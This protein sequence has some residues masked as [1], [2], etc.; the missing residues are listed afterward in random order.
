MGILLADGFDYKARKPLDARILYD[1][2][3]D[4]AGMTDAVMYEGAIA[5]N[6]EDNKFYVF[7]SANTVDPTTGKWRELNTGGN[8]FEY[9]VYDE[10]TTY[11]KGDWVKLYDNSAKIARVVQTHTVPTTSTI[12]DE[13]YEAIN[14]GKI[15]LVNDNTLRSYLRGGNYQKHEIIIDHND[16]LY[17]TTKAFEAADVEVPDGGSGYKIDYCLAEDLRLGNMIPLDKP[18]ISTEYVIGDS[19]K[20]GQTIV[21]DEKIYLVL[22]DFTATDFNTDLANFNLSKV[23][24]NR[25]ESYIM[26]APYKEGSLLKNV[27]T[28][29]LYMATKDFNAS[30]SG[31]LYETAIADD[32]T[33]GNIIKIG[34]NYKFKLYK[35]TQDINKTIDAINELPISTI[36]FENG[37]TVANMVV[38]E[39]VYGPL[40]TLAL[41]KEIDLNNQIIKAK[42]VNSREMEFMPPAPAEHKVVIT[43]PGNDYAVNDILDSSLALFS[44]KITE[45]D[46]NG[47]IV[48]AELIDKT[49]ALS[50]N[51]YGAIIDAKPKLYLGHKKTWYEY[52][53]EGEG[54]N[55]SQQSLLQEYTPGNSYLKNS[56]IIS[57]N[58][59]YKAMINFT[60]TSTETEITDNLKNDIIAG[61]II[62]LTPEDP[63]VPE[64][65][66]SFMSDEAAY[67]PTNAVKG[68]WGLVLDCVQTAPGQ[69]GIALYTDTGWVITPIPKG[70]MDFP[71]PTADGKLYFRTVASGATDGQWAAFESA[72]GSDITI[73]FNTTNDGTY[74]PEVGEPV[75][76][77]GKMLIGDGATDLMSLQPF[78]V[79]NMTQTDLFTLIG[80]TPEDKNNKGQAN[81]YAP[82]GADSL[83]PKSYLP[84]EVT[85]TYSKADIDAKD[86]ATLGAA[87]TLINTESTRATT[88][89]NA[90]ET[91][92]DTHI[93]DTS[94]H[95]TQNE[96][97][98]WN[99]KVNE[100]DL[101]DYDN[102]ISDTAIHVTQ[103][104]K[105]KWDGMNKAYFVTSVGTLPSTD[106]QI[107][108]I[109]YV[110]TSA[111]GV[112]PI[113]CEEYI[114]TGTEW[115]KLDTTGVSIS[116]N[117][118]NLIGKPSATPLTLD[119]T[120]TLAHNHTNKTALDKIGQSDAGEF[121]WNG[122]AIGI[123]AIFLENE[124]ALP[125]IGEENTLYIIY[126][127]SRVRNFPSISVYRN[128]AFQ[129]LGRGTQDAPPTVGGMSILQVEYF[130]VQKNSTFNIT[131]S[132]QTSFC[133]MPVEILKE[134]AGKQNVATTIVDFAETTKIDYNNNLLKLDET[135]KLTFDVKS[136]PT[137]IDTVGD[138]YYSHAD[139]DLADYYD[140]QLIN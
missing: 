135:N 139:I 128:N 122:E 94:L 7:N 106:N 118:D 130:G 87:S 83:V 63:E 95:V 17:F 140:I 109:G 2:L 5:Y 85:D 112:T 127:D 14:S 120:V 52:T 44:I 96:K 76:Y 98:G 65:L 131:I 64:C 3:A 1:T 13:W 113:V 97:D 12:S 67:L 62:R 110:Q 31:S 20:K 137:I 124:N 133:F 36:V 49:T 136:I 10:N 24:D 105:D 117:W 30:T 42:T 29:E 19:Y 75:W 34:E 114:W 28:N 21:K 11:N 33:Q 89:E 116:F 78:Y 38:N 134:Q 53:G 92:I 72:D 103:A 91:K 46:D 37:E 25:V 35:T 6:K 126:E 99:A 100:S 41:I 23:N 15:E 129:I 74:V 57:D 70:E 79:S 101:T 18:A 48:A 9:K 119:N 71:E 61:N 69:P 58:I 55:T 60:A 111:A 123:Q 82:L 54:G 32:I 81:G 47:G 45:V 26:G 40:G 86:T 43:L 66:G 104:D 93:A 56:L 8:G 132:P 138:M 68:N 59:L 90:T 121:T 77:D 4:M 27:T 39:A 88:K 125:D 84:L 102:H 108:N 107:G 16:K 80:Y 22:N 50:T 115:K 51:G 73:T